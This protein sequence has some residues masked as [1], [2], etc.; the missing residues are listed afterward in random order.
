MSPYSKSGRINAMKIVSSAFLSSLNLS[1]RLKRVSLIY[2]IV[3]EINILKTVSLIY[4]I[5]SEINIL[6]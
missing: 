1:Q 3:S 4:F 2:F 5:V 6:I